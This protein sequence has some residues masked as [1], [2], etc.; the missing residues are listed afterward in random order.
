MSGQKRDARA[1]PS[2]LIR[3]TRGLAHDFNNLLAIIT[4]NIQLARDRTDDT[5]TQAL[6]EEA[7]MASAMAAD[8]IRRLK[9]VATDQPMHLESVS[10]ATVLRNALPTFKA[11]A[12]PQIMIEFADEAGAIAILTDRNALLNAILNLV[13]NA[14]DAMPEGGTIKITVRSSRAHAIA[15]SVSDTGAGMTASI[16]KRAFDPYFSTKSPAEGRG[17][18]LASVLGFALQCGGDVAIESAPAKGTH[19][20]LTLPV[21]DNR[22]TPRSGP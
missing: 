20:T 1:A 19:V 3:L 10:P 4:G 8:L 7:E 9:A 14:R 5:K 18:G 2:D 21:V 13:F 12:G 22:L 15:I 11:A 16:L 17:L 6:L